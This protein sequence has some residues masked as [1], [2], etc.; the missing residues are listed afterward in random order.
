VIVILEK[1]LGLGVYGG[2]DGNGW[3]NW[4]RGLGTTFKG[5]FG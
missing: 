3:D 5:W 4:V 2:D 1:D